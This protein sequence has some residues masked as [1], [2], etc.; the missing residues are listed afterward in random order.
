MIQLKKNGVIYKLYDF[1]L[2]DGEKHRLRQTNLCHLTGTFLAAVV[3]SPLL[4]A[5]ALVIL[6]FV[7]LADIAETIGGKLEMRKGLRTSPPSKIKLL[8]EAFH[9]KICPVIR[10]EE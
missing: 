5:L 9:G 4:I 10:F 1:V 3:A 2:P 8:W 6:P 7:F